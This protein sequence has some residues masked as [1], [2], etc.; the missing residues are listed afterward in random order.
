M[1]LHP[2][3]SWRRWHPSQCGP[4]F[5]GM[6][7]YHHRTLAG[8]CCWKQQLRPC[9]GVHVTNQPTHRSVR[10][11]A[12]VLCARTGELQRAAIPY[13]AR[14][15]WPTWQRRPRLTQGLKCA[16]VRQLQC[17][18][19]WQLG[20]VLASTTNGPV[21]T[22]GCCWKAHA[23]LKERLPEEGSHPAQRMVSSEWPSHSIDGTLFRN[24]GL[25]NS[26]QRLQKTSLKVAETC[27]QNFAVVDNIPAR[28]RLI[29]KRY[30]AR[31]HVTIVS[32]M[33]RCQRAC[34][35][36]C[37]ALRLKRRGALRLKCHGVGMWAVHERESN[38]RYPRSP[39]RELAFRCLCACVARDGR[40]NCSRQAANAAI[41]GRQGYLDSGAIWTV[42]AQTRVV[43]RS[44][45]EFPRAVATRLNLYM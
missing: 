16:D 23:S 18:S 42:C 44:A 13:P 8:K 39:G 40:M 5:G 43:C 32:F 15:G 11:A 41:R 22:P 2:A 29:N 25:F 28:P 4:C 14:D 9:G 36:L 31:S 17:P 20:V 10:S 38:A 1:C 45:C 35:W 37:Y 26:V 6:Y 27:L 3:R 34:C 19:R 7:R 21:C 30:T 12:V 33:E 24:H